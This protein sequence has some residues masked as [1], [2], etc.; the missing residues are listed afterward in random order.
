MIRV[1]FVDDEVN[2]LHAMGRSLHHMRKEWSMEFVASGVAALEA[3]AARPADVIVSDMRMPGM[4]GWQLL[5][6]VKLR[7]PQTVRLILSGHADPVSIMR[8]VGTAHQYLAKPCESAE[9]KAAIARTEMLR[10]HLNNATLALLVGHVGTLPS[11]PRAFQEILD[12]LQRPEASVADAAAI[13]GRDVAMTANVMKLV[14]SAFFGAPQPVRTVDRA[15]AYLGLETLCALVLGHSIFKSD[16]T[17]AAQKQKLEQLLTHSLDTAIT[18]RVIARQQGLSVAESEHAYLAGM[19]N[20]VGRVV[21]TMHPALSAAGPRD[22]AFEGVMD[23]ERHHAEIGAYLLGLWA[24][25]SPIVEA[26]AFHH[27]PSEMPQ[28][29]LTLTRLVHFADRMSHERHP[30][31]SDQVEG[32]LEPELLERLGLADRWPV[33]RQTLDELE[34]PGSLP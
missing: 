7:H 14:N 31:G 17:S 21:I 13:I 15:V 5:A 23:N 6:E 25:P 32:E 3:L 9:L 8:S 33:W 22:S 30:G 24:F 1:L 27:R 12:C 28:Q 10:R 29:G 4:D 26:T 20:D 11:V 34:S 18:A 19:L 2:V 16:L